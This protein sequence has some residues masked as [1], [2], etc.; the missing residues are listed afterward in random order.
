MDRIFINLKMKLTQGVI[1]TLFWGYIHVSDAY[2][3]TSVLVYI[4]SHVHVHLRFQV[5]V[6]RTIGPLVC[7]FDLVLNI[8][9][10]LN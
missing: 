10:L 1:L 4:Y 7:S 5:S 3:Q 8:H 6:N 9:S 2:C